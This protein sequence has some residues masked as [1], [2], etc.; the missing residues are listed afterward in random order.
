MNVI[1]L[2]GTP[3]QNPYWETGQP[4]GDGSC[5]SY[6]RFAANVYQWNDD[7]CTENLAYVCQLGKI[8]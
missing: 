2:L 4:S 5:I 7:Q 8:R 3:I 6:Q 1:V